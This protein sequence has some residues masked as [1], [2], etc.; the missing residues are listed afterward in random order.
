MPCHEHQA[1]KGI[2]HC[3]KPTRPHWDS[4]LHCKQLPPEQEMKLWLLLY[5]CICLLI[6]ACDWLIPQHNPDRMIPSPCLVLISTQWAR[7]PASPLAEPCSCI[8][9]QQRG[10]KVLMDSPSTPTQTW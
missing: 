1:V 6:K 9:T 8:L 3:R 4:W 7:A 5:L 10:C 2:P